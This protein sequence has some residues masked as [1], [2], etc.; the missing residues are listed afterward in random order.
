[1]PF[2]AHE[3]MEAHEM[4][5]EKVNL[6]NHFSLYAEQC[7]DQRLRQMLQTHLN[8]A[9]RH[10]D[11]LV[12]YTHDY[13][14]ASGG[15]QVYGMPPSSPQ[16]VKYGLHQPMPQIPQMQGR[17]NDSQI[18]LAMLSFHKQSAKSQMAASLECA[19]PNL[20]QMLVDGAVTCSNQAY[21]VFLFMNEQ[22]QYQ[23]P[24]IHDHT[25]KTFLHSYK[26][27]EM[28]GYPG[29]PAG[30]TLSSEYSSYNPYNQPGMSANSSMY[31][32]SFQSN[33]TNHSTPGSGMS[34]YGQNSSGM[35][36]QSMTAGGS[37][38]RSTGSISEQGYSSMT[39]RAASGA[40]A[41]MTSG[42]MTSGSSAISGSS[43]GT[44]PSS[45]SS[46]VGAS[47]AGGG[48]SSAA[49]HNGSAMSSISSASL[50]ETEDS[51]GNQS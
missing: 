16:Q 34:R 29:Q 4:L 3:T 22:G 24:T 12:A 38:A 14:A 44:A 10:Y 8:T 5:N 6:I 46:A 20:R 33:Q 2:G 50:S 43:S 39:S 51:A 27:M 7:Q 37:A 41:S 21:E 48:A 42:A 45:S 11:Q 28:G 15:P 26:P 25:A 23:V 18:L 1:M 36:F 17:L 35:G 13:S 49:Q 30:A 32:S 47:A 9:I 31:S 19:D 40:G